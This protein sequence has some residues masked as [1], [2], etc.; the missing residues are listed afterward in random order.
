M[1]RSSPQTA[2][3]QSADFLWVFGDLQQGVMQGAL[4]SS[5]GRVS[6]PSPTLRCTDELVRMQKQQCHIYTWLTQC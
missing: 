1:Q 6:S 5:Q 3:V 2:F 4:S